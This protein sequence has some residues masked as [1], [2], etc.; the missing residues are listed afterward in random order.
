MNRKSLISAATA[1]LLTATASFAQSLFDFPG[2]GPQ[3]QA[4]PEAAKPVEFDYNFDFQYF[5]DY[6]EFGYSDD[7]FMA[8]ETYHLARLT[9]SFGIRVNTDNRFTHRILAG[10]DIMKNLGENPIDDLIYSTDEAEASLLNAKLFRSMILYYNLSSDTGR[11][12]FDLYAGIYPRT[13]L[14]GEY[15]RAIFSESV[16]MTDPDLEGV[17]VKYEGRKFLAEAGIDW[18][19]SMGL[20]RRERYMAYT[21]GSFKMFDWLSAGWDATYTHV[22]D[23][24][25]FSTCVDNV[26]A[27]PFIKMDFGHALG[28]QEFSIKGGALASMQLDSDME[29]VPHFPVG[30]EAVVTLKNWGLGIENTVYYGDNMMPY[31]SSSYT[32]LTDTSHY[33]DLLYFGE[34]FFFTRRGYASGYDRLELFYEPFVSN[35]LSMRVSAVGH[36]IFPMSEAIGSFLGWQAKASLYFNLDTVRNPQKPQGT[37]KSSRKNVE[38]TNPHSNGPEIRL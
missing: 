29:T 30:A 26:M 23:S 22:G 28:M 17:T 31:R 27:N 32:G 9:P 24:Y 2:F 1:L 25:I 3:P 38:R 33:T 34:P 15:S 21:A 6:R 12:K 4:R 37:H 14:D 10:V 20:D 35:G 5:F 11:G 8:S 36:C 7:M 19:G 16:K 18:L 13:V